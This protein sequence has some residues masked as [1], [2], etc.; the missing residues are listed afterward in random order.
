MKF[1]IKL[2]YH[3]VGAEYI[4]IDQSVTGTIRWTIDDDIKEW[5]KLVAPDCSFTFDQHAVY[6][7]F[8][9]EESEILFIL[10]FSIPAD[11]LG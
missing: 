2:P 8:T 5:V 11:H 1:R 3:Y 7:H 6:I 9:N 4:R 10:T